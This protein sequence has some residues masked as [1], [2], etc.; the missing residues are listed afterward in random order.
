M[1]SRS[2][3]CFTDDV[4]LNW[5]R[6]SPWLLCDG[7]NG[8]LAGLSTLPFVPGG[9]RSLALPVVFV[10][11]ERG[12]WKIL[13]HNGDVEDNNKTNLEEELA[14]QRV[15]PHKLDRLFRSSGS[16]WQPDS[17]M[18][19]AAPSLVT[20]ASCYPAVTHPC[21]WRQARRRPGGYSCVHQPA[22]TVC[23]K[24]HFLAAPKTR[25]QICFV[26]KII[27]LVMR[28]RGTALKVPSYPSEIKILELTS[29]LCCTL[30]TT[31]IA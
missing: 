23:G 22:N 3:F 28:H 6:T 13:R 10:S 21:C 18:E 2:G 12:E 24:R 19:N 16:T 17:S 31:V 14:C 1:G 8:F 27:Q 29:P 7:S 26:A 11:V 5:K 20:A 30:L 4:E 25:L 9:S 15:V